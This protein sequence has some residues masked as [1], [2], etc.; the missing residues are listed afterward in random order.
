MSKCYYLLVSAN[1]CDGFVC[2]FFNDS[3]QLFH[4]I[5]E[6]NWIIFDLTK[7]K[8][9]VASTTN[10]RLTNVELTMQDTVL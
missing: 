9:N 10:Q 7:L 6:L 8:W 1:K 5:Y 4:A 2:A 3:V